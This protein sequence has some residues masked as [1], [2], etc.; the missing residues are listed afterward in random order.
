[1]WGAVQQ[2]AA[3]APGVP[4]YVAVGGVSPAGPPAT[5]IITMTE[6][7][8]PEELASDEEYGDILEDMREECSKA[9]AVPPQY[10]TALHGAL[11]VCYTSA[12]TSHC[13]M[14][15]SHVLE[16]CPLLLWRGCEVDHHGYVAGAARISGSFKPQQGAAL[17]PCVFKATRA[18]NTVRW[19]AWCGQGCSCAGARAA[20]GPL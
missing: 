17:Y 9:R 16:T 12:V 7:V 6:A 4:G 18:V 19:S 1:M 10:L 5:R 2:S 11:H 14:E 3:G 8:T 15:H 20:A 13:A